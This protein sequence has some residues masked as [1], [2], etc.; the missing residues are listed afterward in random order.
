[1]RNGKQESIVNEMTSQ[2]SHHKTGVK[3]SETLS[4]IDKFQKY[5]DPDM[6]LREHSPVVLPFPGRLSHTVQYRDIH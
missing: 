6:L 4:W 5:V 1:M 2:G 3:A